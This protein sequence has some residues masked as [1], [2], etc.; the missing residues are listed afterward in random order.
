MN[1]SHTQIGLQA[2]IRQRFC[3]GTI[4]K[5]QLPTRLYPSCQWQQPVLP[6]SINH[7]WSVP[8]Y[9]VLSQC[10]R[11]SERSDRI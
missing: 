11:A 2:L 10:V 8:T 6:I 7:I 1:A 9:Y 5:C 3:R 4:L